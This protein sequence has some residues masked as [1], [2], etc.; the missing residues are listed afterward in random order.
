MAIVGYLGPGRK[1]ICESNQKQEISCQTSFKE[2]RHCMFVS[3]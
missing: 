3:M 1:L 2:Q